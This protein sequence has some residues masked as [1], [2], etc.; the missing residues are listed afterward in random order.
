MGRVSTLCPV[1]SP[2]PCVCTAR[3]TLHQGSAVSPCVHHLLPHPCPTPPLP[4]ELITTP[5]AHGTAPGSPWEPQHQSPLLQDSRDGDGDRDGQAHCRQEQRALPP[6]SEQTRGK[7]SI[8]HS[9]RTPSWSDPRTAQSWAAPAG[10]SWAAPR[11]LTLAPLP[12]PTTPSLSPPCIFSPDT[13][14]NWY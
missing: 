11:S 3:V 5:R 6:G 12:L 4:H 9:H 8:L 13:S 10:R 2:G 7:H 1:P 14:W